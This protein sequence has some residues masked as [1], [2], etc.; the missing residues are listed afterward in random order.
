MHRRCGAMARRSKPRM[1]LACDRTLR[2]LM[3][4]RPDVQS[5]A[6][7][8]ECL[9]SRWRVTAHKNKGST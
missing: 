3:A 8:A 4:G 6:R 5:E 2:L 7:L 1:I 9:A